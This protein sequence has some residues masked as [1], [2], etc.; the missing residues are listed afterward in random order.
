MASARHMAQDRGADGHRRGQAGV[1]EEA[2]GGAEQR[3]ASGEH[4][5]AVAD[6]VDRGAD[7]VRV[8]DAVSGDGVDEVRV[9]HVEQDAL[10]GA[11]FVDAT[12]R[13]QPGGAVPGD[14]GRAAE[15]GKARVAVEPGALLQFG[16]AGAV[17]DDE[18]GVDAGDADVADGAV[19]RGVALEPAREIGD[20]VLLGE[21]RQRQPLGGAGLG[22][23]D[24][25][26]RPPEMILLEFGVQRGERLLPEERDGAVDQHER[27]EHDQQ[28]GEGAQRAP[29]ARRAAPTAAASIR[30]GF[31]WCRE[32]R[33]RSRSG[34][35]PG[36]IL[37]A[38]MDPSA[39]GRRIL[40]C[41]NAESVPP[42]DPGPA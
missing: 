28:G 2:L 42:S 33:T 38:S 15:T 18:A 36:G 37:R 39:S 29:A 26:Q 1:H 14:R 6:L 24:P 21:L 7:V 30:E 9:G 23:F 31:W 19:G 13:R 25:A 11:Q 34:R 17:D 10:A 32:C 16:G 4:E 22:V 35:P 20:A 40:Q 27:A 41:R 12:E 3:S 8:D 5:A